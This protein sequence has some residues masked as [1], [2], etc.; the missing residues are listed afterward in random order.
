MDTHHIKRHSRLGAFDDLRM[1]GLRISRVIDDFK[2][3]SKTHPKPSF[4]PTEGDKE[5]D[6][7][8]SCIKVF[9]RDDLLGT[10]LKIGGVMGAD[11]AQ[12][13]KN[14]SFSSGARCSAACS[15]FT[16]IC[17]CKPSV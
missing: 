17:A 15:C 7:I 4:W 8:E 10:M 11:P 1:S 13:M 6:S 2:E 9:I 12:L 14:T 5:I 3:L 16:S